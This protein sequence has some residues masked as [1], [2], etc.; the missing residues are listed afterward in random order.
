MDR[1]EYTDESYARPHVP[2][3][4]A[5]V[6]DSRADPRDAAERAKDDGDSDYSGTN[7]ASVDRGREDEAL[8]DHGANRGIGSGGDQAEP[9][10]QPDE[11]VPDEGDIDVPGRTPDEVGPGQG[12]FDRP[13]RTPA[14]TPPQPDTMPTET[15]PPD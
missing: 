9:G 3:G 1:D 12:D 15:P 11:I 4:T 13:G 5:P 10:K 14:E 2:P 7:E 6:I 8:F